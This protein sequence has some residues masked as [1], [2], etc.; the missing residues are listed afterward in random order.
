M[1]DPSRQDS[2][3]R[4][5]QFRVRGH[6]DRGRSSWFEGL[7]ITFT[8]GDTLLTGSVQDQTALYSIL[9]KLRDLGLELVSVEQLPGLKD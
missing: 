1:T 3:A 2:I 5:Y 4:V 8:N 6:L 9:D 7:E